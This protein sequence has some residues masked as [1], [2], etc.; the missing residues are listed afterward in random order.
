MLTFLL[1][2][3]A[4]MS[5]AQNRYKKV[6]KYDVY[7]TDWALFKTISGTYGFLDRRGEVAVQPVYTK[8]EKFIFGGNELAMVRNISGA[9]GFINRQGKEIIPA[10]YWTKQEAIAQLKRLKY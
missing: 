8:I 9:Y 6:Y 5:F 7:N 1:V 4:A 10:I 3:L 2:T